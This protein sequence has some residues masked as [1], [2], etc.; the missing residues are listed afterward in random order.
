M[1]PVSEKYF[2]ID[3]Q[4]AIDFCNIS[5]LV[6]ENA[7]RSLKIRTDEPIS[8]GTEDWSRERLKNRKYSQSQELT[9]S[10]FCESMSTTKSNRD[11]SEEFDPGSD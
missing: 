11:Q 2:E 5:I 3:L 6:A 4:N 7:T 8:V 1:F 10:H 9:T